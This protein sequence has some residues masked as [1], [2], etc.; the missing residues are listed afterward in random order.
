MRPGHVPAI[1][2]LVVKRAYICDWGHYVDGDYAILEQLSAE[3]VDGRSP[4]ERPA[5]TPFHALTL[6][7]DPL[8]ILQL[9][10][11][12]MLLFAFKMMSFLS[13]MMNFV[14]KL[15]YLPN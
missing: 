13:T 7:F 4:V 6:P 14:S 2:A 12:R 3:Q 10:K 5:M 9:A 8:Y 1:T 15:M 11:V